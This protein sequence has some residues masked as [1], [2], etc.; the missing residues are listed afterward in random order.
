VSPEVHSLTVQAISST[1]GALLCRHKTVLSSSLQAR[2][3][4]E[5]V[6]CVEREFLPKVDEYESEE[7]KQQSGQPQLFD[8][9]D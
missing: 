3:Q 2:I 9:C 4:I 1:F 8:F 5:A 7:I 6:E